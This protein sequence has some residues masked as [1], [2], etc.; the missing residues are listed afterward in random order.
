M[1]STTTLTSLFLPLLALSAPT[2]DG[3]GLKVCG[4][5]GYLN[6]KLASHGAGGGFNLDRHFLKGGAEKF[7]DAVCSLREDAVSWL[8]LNS[9]CR[10]RFYMDEK[11]TVEHSTGSLAQGPLQEY[12]GF[13]GAWSYKCGWGYE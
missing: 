13:E 4:N 1:K 3:S 9:N 12:K 8:T 2:P 11:C 7:K 10:C 5:A 6:G